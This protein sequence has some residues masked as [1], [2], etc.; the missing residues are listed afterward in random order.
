MT[1]EEERPAVLDEL[2]AALARLPPM[3]AW[4][5]DASCGDLGLDAADVFTQDRPEPEELALA[6][7][8][9]RRCPVLS[10]CCAYAARA[11]VYGLWAGAWHD[12][13]RSRKAAA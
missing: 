11:P 13:R 3:G 12:G 2:A 6:E 5:L 9:C 4:V 10:D 8:V 1:V 7:R